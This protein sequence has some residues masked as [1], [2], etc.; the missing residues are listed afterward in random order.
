M[1]KQRESIDHYT[2][3][4]GTKSLVGCSVQ[5]IYQS[6]E[7]ECNSLNDPSNSLCRHE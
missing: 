1:I 6:N 3:L 4:P 2:H 5:V 7:L